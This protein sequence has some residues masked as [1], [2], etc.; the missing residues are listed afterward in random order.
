MTVRCLNFAGF[1]ECWRR[2][3]VGEE[4]IYSWG[5]EALRHLKLPPRSAKNFPGISG[6][7]RVSISS[8]KLGKGNLET[9][10]RFSKR[11]IQILL[12]QSLL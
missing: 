7:F 4:L 6:G 9:K 2:L 3:D 8:A 5:S 1:W 12:Y 11:L 10:P